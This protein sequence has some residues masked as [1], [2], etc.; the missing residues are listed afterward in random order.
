MKGSG[1][2]I[3]GR[4]CW[5][6]Y[7]G[8][9]NRSICVGKGSCTG[10]D[11]LS[12]ARDDARNRIAMRTERAAA[13]VENPPTRAQRVMEGSRQRL[14]N[15]ADVRRARSFFNIGKKPGTRGGAL[16]GGDLLSDAREEARNRIAMRTEQRA[17]RVENPPTREQR[18]MEGSRERMS[19]AA[20]V[21][22]AMFFNKG[23][24][25]GTR[26]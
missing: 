16:T 13:R 17:A 2:Y 19:K 24:M 7:G 1:A 9:T 22:R 11:I 4:P 6:E 14:N 21:R 12:D 23:M 10:G 8:R 20:D 5:R 3:Y 15:A 18:A 26:V 25:T